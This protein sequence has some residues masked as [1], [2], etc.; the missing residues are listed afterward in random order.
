MG[1][2]LAQHVPTPSRAVRR[3]G[4]PAVHARP[5]GDRREA[6]HAPSHPRGLRARQQERRKCLHSD[7]FPIKKEPLL[8]PANEIAGR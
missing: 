4:G 8:P 6:Q 5:P 1:R 7:I 2:L 3:A